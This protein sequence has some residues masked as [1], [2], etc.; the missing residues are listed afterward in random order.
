M[1]TAFINKCAVAQRTRKLYQH[2]CNVRSWSGRGIGY[3][4][5]DRLIDGVGHLDRGNGICCRDQVLH[6]LGNQSLTNLLTLG[7]ADAIFTMNLVNTTA[8]NT[9]MRMVLQQEPPGNPY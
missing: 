8:A 2:L 6:R 7:E 9:I 4:D 1:F 3:D 5:G